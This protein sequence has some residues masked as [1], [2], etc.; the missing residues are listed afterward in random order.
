MGCW[1]HTCA[2]TKL[3]IFR[4]DPV[5]VILLVKQTEEFRIHR[6]HPTAYWAPIPYY[7]EGEYDDYGGVENCH[8]PLLPTIISQFKK[9]LFEYKLGDNPYHD[10][11]VN[12]EDFNVDLLFKAD[13]E[14]R[15]SVKC[16]FDTTNPVPVKH[17]VIK[18][19]VFDYIIQNYTYSQYRRCD[20]EK[21]YEYVDIGFNNIHQEGIEWFNNLKNRKD[22]DEERLFMYHN[23]D[24]NFIGKVM[25]SC[26]YSTK[27]SYPDLFM[28]DCF[29]NKEFEL[30][31]QIVAQ[32]SSLYWITNFLDSIRTHWYP[33]I[34]LGS[35]EGEVEQYQLFA[36][37][38]NEE[39][40]NI[41][42]KWD[43]YEYEEDEVSDDNDDDE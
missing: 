38:I 22:K 39:C 18:K 7:F 29:R 27:L 28:F 3:P 9:V 13:H 37:L 23:I 35:Q 16:R 20:N 4:G 21:G 43:E 30:I 25:D 36:K 10:I 24:R 26:K 5:V 17:V 34:G 12:R 40:Q 14:N 8:G 41:N 31:E 32:L 2:I 19:S 42:N 11:P 15:L 33:C 6:T 1:N